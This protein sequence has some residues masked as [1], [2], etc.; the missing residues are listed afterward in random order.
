[1]ANW[2]K[3]KIT[4]IKRY[5]DFIQIVL[6]DYIY[7]W[8]ET[9]LPNNNR[10]PTLTFLAGIC[11]PF[12]TWQVGDYIEVDLDKSVN[13][14][15]CSIINDTS[16]VRKVSS[17]SSTNIVTTRGSSSDIVISSGL[18]NA[19]GSSETMEL[20]RHMSRMVDENNKEYELK[21]E[22][23]SNK[24]FSYSLICRKQK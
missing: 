11:Y 20:A 24:R 13:C 12:D 2:K 3:V 19:M 14:N 6:D 22:D 23:N 4:E 18:A 21:I 7:V 16:I 15:H 8:G 17:S 10:L 5:E 9:T 1:M